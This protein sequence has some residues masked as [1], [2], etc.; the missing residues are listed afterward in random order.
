MK[1]LKE[2]SGSNMAVMIYFYSPGCSACKILR[3]KVREMVSDNFPGIA[4]HEVNAAEHPMITAEA[5]V[6]ASPAILVFF[7]GKEYLRESKY[8]SVDQLKNKISRYYD[9]LFS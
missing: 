4:F 2:I 8:I 3:P 5:S 6:F 1:T 7:E 9:L